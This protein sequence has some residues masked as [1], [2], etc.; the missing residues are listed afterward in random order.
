[1]TVSALH[2]TPL[3][4]PWYP[5]AGEQAEEQGVPAVAIV[6][7]HHVT[8]GVWNKA[9]WPS[10]TVEETQCAELEDRARGLGPPGPEEGKP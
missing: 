6:H 9:N 4:G 2:P 8:E 10:T 7:L 1:M 3:A 5:G